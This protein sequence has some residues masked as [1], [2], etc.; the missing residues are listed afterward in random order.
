MFNEKI[1]PPLVLTLICI[2][3]CGL[4]VAAYEATYVDTTGVI[5][6]KLTAGL[7]EVYG[8]AEGF[9]M[10]KNDDGTVLT[11]DGVTSV[12]FDGENTA[13]E[14]TA[15]GYSSGGL[16]VLVGLNNSG[17]VSGVSVMTIGETPGVGTKVQDDSFKNQFKGVKYGDTVSADTGETKVKAKAV[18]G[19][20]DE[21]KRLKLDAAASSSSGSGFELDAISGATFSSNGMYNAV[22]TA[23]AAYEEMKGA[24]E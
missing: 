24:D 13:F 17:A 11:Y 21:I 8:S 4:L 9:E 15:D 2:I 23:L 20:R 3:T 10:L 6:E 18:W 14:I 12:L 22:K 1:K 5:T 16:H 7:T 19:T